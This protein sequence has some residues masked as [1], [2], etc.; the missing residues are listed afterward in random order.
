[1]ILA[2]LQRNWDK[3]VY[4]QENETIYYKE[5]AQIHEEMNKKEVIDLCGESQTM[6]SDHCKTEQNK[7]MRKHD[8]EESKT[9]AR[10]A[11]KNRPEKDFQAQETIR[12]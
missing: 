12:Q 10:K 2:E 5:K 8:M 1:M 11:N 3:H 7:K 9:D 4:K 6:T